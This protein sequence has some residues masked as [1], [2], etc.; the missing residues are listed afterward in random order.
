MGTRAFTP[1]E[2]KLL[3][4]HRY[5][6]L[7]DSE[8]VNNTYKVTGR[9]FRII[10]KTDC[11]VSIDEVVGDASEVYQDEFDSLEELLG[12]LDFS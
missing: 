2:I 5:K 4:A 7:T 11:Y 1:E 6:R 3:T 9:V 10:K 8:F 12:C